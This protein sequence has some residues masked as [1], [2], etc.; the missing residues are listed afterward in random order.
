VGGPSRVIVPRIEDC[1]IPRNPRTDPQPGYKVLGLDGQLRSV[2]RREGNTL[3]CQ[4]GAM[5][6]KTTVQRWNE[7]CNGAAS[8]SEPS[9]EKE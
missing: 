5:R 1:M 3:W 4:D 2:T 8:T 7:W 6:Y 9:S